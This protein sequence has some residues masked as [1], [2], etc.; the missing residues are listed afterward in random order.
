MNALEK[1]FL[2]WAYR[3]TQVTVRGNEDLKLYAG[4]EISEG[5]FHAQ[6]IKATQQARDAEIKKTSATYDTKLRTLNDKLEREQR[7]LKQDQAV[8]SNRKNGSGRYC[9]GN[10]R[11]LVRIGS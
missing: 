7:E 5:D 1:D 9:S 10:C 11:R 3:T 2:D 8:L 4:P 6:C